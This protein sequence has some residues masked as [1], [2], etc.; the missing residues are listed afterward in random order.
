VAQFGAD[1]DLVRISIEYGRDGIPCVVYHTREGAIPSYLYQPKVGAKPLPSVWKAP[2]VQP[3]K[4]TEPKAQKSEEKASSKASSSDSSE[5]S[6]QR[7][8][9]PKEK[10]IKSV[11]PKAKIPSTKS[12]RSSKKISGKVAGVEV[13]D[14]MKKKYSLKEW[15][16]LSNDDRLAITVAK[17]TAALGNSFNLKDLLEVRLQRFNA[18]FP[19]EAIQVPSGDLEKWVNLVDPSVNAKILASQNHWKEIVAPRR[20]L[21]TVDQKDPK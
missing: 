1:P 3:V 10:P 17:T 7:N 14:L 19:Q 5:S 20:I 21:V 9:S 18:E 11:P 16:S 15:E 8:I 4:P 12:K 13:S 2:P 6:S